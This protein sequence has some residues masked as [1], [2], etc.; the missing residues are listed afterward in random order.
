MIRRKLVHLFSKSLTPEKI[1]LSIIVGL[2]LGIIPVLGFTTLLCTGAAAALR[3]NLPVIQL[4]NGLVT[5]VQLALLI[6]FLRM[7]EWLFHVRHSAWTVHGILTL[8]HTNLGKAL[9]TLGTATL[10]AL[11]AWAVSGMIVAIVAYM[12]LVPLLRRLL[13]RHASAAHA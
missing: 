9:A 4:V 7:G 2:M 12:V 6:P 8:I 3:L 5:P 13:S 11:V 10:H 1:A